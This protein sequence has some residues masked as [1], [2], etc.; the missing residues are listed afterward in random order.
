MPDIVIIMRDIK[1]ISEIDGGGA[2]FDLFTFCMAGCQNTIWKT[3][4]TYLVRNFK[5]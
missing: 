3:N 4:T 1:K 2:L 5:I